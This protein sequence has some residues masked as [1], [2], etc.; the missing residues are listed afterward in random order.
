MYAFLTLPKPAPAIAAGVGIVISRVCVYMSVR[1]VKEKQLEQST[2]KSTDIQ[3]MA[4]A[5]NAFL[6][7][8]ETEILAFGRP[9]G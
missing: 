3:S 8:A 2:L 6:V 7:S 4:V 1:A 9:L 5:R